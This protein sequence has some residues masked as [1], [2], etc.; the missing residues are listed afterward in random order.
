LTR[1]ER[2]QPLWKRNL[3]YL[4]DERMKEETERWVSKLKE[5]NVNAQKKREMKK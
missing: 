1:K 5:L 3:Q 4:K 2:K